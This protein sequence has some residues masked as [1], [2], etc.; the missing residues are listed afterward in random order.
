VCRP[1]TVPIPRHP[2]SG[3]SSRDLASTTLEN[4]RAFRRCPYG[5]GDQDDARRIAVNVAKLPELLRKQDY[6]ST[7]SH[8]SNIFISRPSVSGVTEAHSRFW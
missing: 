8:G 6:F 3:A 5:R 1:R 4:S 7:I 2:A